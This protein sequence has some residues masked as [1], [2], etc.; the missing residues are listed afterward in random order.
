MKTQETI[1]L[2]NALDLRSYE[3]REYGCREVTI[4]FKKDNHGDEIV[5]YM[6]MDADGLFKCYELKVTLSDLKSDAKKSWYGDL[7]YL[8]VSKSLYAKNP[9]FENYI[10]PYVGILVGEELTVK[11]KAKK[12]DITVEQREMLKNSLIRSVFWKMD[13]FRNAD[14]LDKYRHLE[15]ELEQTKQ[16]FE[17]FKI[18][19]DRKTWTYD[20]FENWYRKNHQDTKMTLESLAKEERRQ[21]TLRKENHFSWIKQD[22]AFFCPNCQKTSTTDTNYC[23]HCGA[24]LRRLK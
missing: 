19:N 1:A 22:D 17:T 13:H 6:S 24:D 23:P 14:N 3:R 11:K 9:V 7:N 5:D 16:E 4:G 10:P 18:A 20:D 21:Y 2:E 15:R 8:V 12:K